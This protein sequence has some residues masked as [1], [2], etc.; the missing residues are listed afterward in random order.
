MKVRT[1]FGGLADSRRI[2][3]MI[4]DLKQHVDIAENKRPM[5]W[6]V[7][8]INN[9]VLHR[10]EKPDRYFYLVAC[11]DQDIIGVIEA[12]FRTKKRLYLMKGFVEPAFRRR[13]I[14]RSLEKQLVSHATARKVSEIELEVRTGNKEGMATWESLG[15]KAIKTIENK[16]SSKRIMRKSVGASSVQY[17]ERESD[18]GMAV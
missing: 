3:E 18:T 17:A 4:R 13:G 10:L 2:A 14:M 5:R 11:F 6:S 16:T 8:K 12:H 9:H 1:R 7:D 15:Y